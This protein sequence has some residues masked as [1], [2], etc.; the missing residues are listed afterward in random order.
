MFDSNSR[1]RIV[2]LWFVA[3][4]GNG[5]TLPNAVFAYDVVIV[6]GSLS[7]L[8]AA[9]TLGRSHRDVLVVDHHDHRHGNHACNRFQAQSYNLLT[10]D[11]VPPRQLQALARQNVEA[12]PSVHLQQGNVTRIHTARALTTGTSTSTWTRLT[13][14]VE[15]SSGD[16][17]QAKKLI[18]ATGMK[19]VL[20]ETLVG[21][22]ECW[23]KTVIHC[24][25]W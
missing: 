23:G 13:F 19:D 14:T 18:L 2:F 15:T 16:T 12:Y 22:E 24:P 4:F 25:Y 21:I 9:L 5:H 20:P 7:G 17:F 8:S 6:G 3:W 11:G 1:R 10:H